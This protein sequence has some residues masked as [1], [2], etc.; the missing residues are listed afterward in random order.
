MECN[1]R[2]EESLE[3]RSR[4]QEIQPC[5][6][7]FICRYGGG[8]TPLVEA[9]SGQKLWT[10]VGGVRPLHSTMRK[11]SCLLMLYIRPTRLFAEE[12]F[13]GAR[14]IFADGCTS[15]IKP[16]RLG[17]QSSSFQGIYIPYICVYVWINK[18][19]SCSLLYTTK[20]IQ[21]LTGVLQSH[22]MWIYIV[23]IRPQLTAELW[24]EL[25]VHVKI[26]IVY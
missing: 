24:Y 26:Y 7:G 15:R 17:L 5:S 22:S 2:R 3:R 6:Q 20:T 12:A 9:T 14:R 16:W 23:M 18:N 11:N 10:G 8:L 21:K 1:S 4:R 19:L 25:L 13:I